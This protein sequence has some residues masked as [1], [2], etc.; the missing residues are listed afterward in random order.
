MKY[1]RK[2]SSRASPTRGIKR[3]IEA[4]CAILLALILAGWSAPSASF[5]EQVGK[6]GDQGMGK[7]EKMPLKDITLTIVYDNNPY[8]KS[9]Q[10]AW[11]FS[12]VI[13]GAEK[14]ILF[15]TGGD[16]TMLL[17]NMGKL[18]IEPL[19]IDAIVLSHIHSDHT[20]GLMDFLRRNPDVVLYLPKSFP[21]GFK[22][23]VRS[24]GATVVEISEPTGIC[25][26]VYS[27]GELGSYL[28]EQSLVVA[29]DKGS[30]VITG[31]GHPGIVR[32]V[33]AAKEMIPG[34]VGLI[35]GGFH[36][37]GETKQGIEKTIS[38]LMTLKVTHVGP[39]HC[40]GTL[41]R[42]LFQRAWGQNYMNVG[43]GRAIHI[44]NLE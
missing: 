32:I 20:G 2:R 42:E 19:E 15:D 43:V 39:C 38:Q 3:V 29:T 14:T 11:G 35:L 17:S 44:P 27:T 13:K 23:E 31:C 1:D 24:Q 6:M 8:E 28:Q 37:Q 26:G 22:K 4:G 18:G 9:L 25:R 30:I 21:E 16:G 36:L 34:S 5:G 40:S 33:E 7:P 10:T 12:C 41:A